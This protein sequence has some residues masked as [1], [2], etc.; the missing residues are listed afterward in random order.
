MRTAAF[1]VL[2]IGVSLVGCKGNDKDKAPAP[3][4]SPVAG[5]AA[6]GSV[7]AGSAAAGSAAAGSAAA[8]SAAAGSA[9]TGSAAAAGSAAGSAA[10]PA[11]PTAAEPAKLAE[12]EVTPGCFA[13]STSKQSAVC[14]IGT[15]GLGVTPELTLVY[16]GTAVSPAPLDVE[17]AGNGLAV[18]PAAAKSISETLARDGYTTFA[19]APQ[20]ISDKP[21]VVGG[22]AFT[23]TSKR[24]A[25]GGEN[26]PPT[27][28]YTLTAKCGGKNVVVHENESEGLSVTA[29]VRAPTAELI[30]I[31]LVDVIA[32]EGEMSKTHHA[33]VFEVKACDAVN[34][35][36]A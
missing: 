8:G 5:S 20:N 11:K 7:T 3:A 28:K 29:T 32:R 14:V 4:P 13:W 18:T 35:S 27:H 24:T 23:L 33:A 9:D 2:S 22:V 17:P 36:A 34:A 1:L 12:G 25:K 31:D 16:V 19:S 21:V 30:V 26:M 6:A 15:T 10:E